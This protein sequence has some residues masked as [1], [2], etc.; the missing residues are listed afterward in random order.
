MPGGKCKRVIQ[1]YLP[2][3]VLCAKKMKT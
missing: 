3:F 2:Q 1:S